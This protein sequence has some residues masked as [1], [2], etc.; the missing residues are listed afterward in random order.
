MVI[1][2]FN[3]N[4]D[5]SNSWELIILITGAYIGKF[6]EWKTMQT[7]SES[8]RII[9]LTTKR[10]TSI[11]LWMLV[12]TSNCQS[13]W[14]SL[15]LSLIYDSKVVWIIQ[16]SDKISANIWIYEYRI[17]IW[18]LFN[19]FPAIGVPWGAPIPRNFRFIIWK[20]IDY[21]SFKS[22]PRFLKM[23]LLRND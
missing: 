12:P 10:S 15:L 21:F 7:L 19:N 4:N 6:K 9:T 3:V 5:L 22:I 18:Y 11:S 23:L 14:R 8:I 1:Y 13:T 2:W 17:R 20:Y 16:K